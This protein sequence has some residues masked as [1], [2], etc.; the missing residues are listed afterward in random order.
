MRIGK[1][2][3]NWRLLEQLSLRDAGKIIGISAATLMWIERGK[4]PDGSTLLLL[5]GWLFNPEKDKPRKEESDGGR[6]QSTGK[7]DE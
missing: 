4:V 1:V 6:V 7:Q 2:L 5:Q 3:S